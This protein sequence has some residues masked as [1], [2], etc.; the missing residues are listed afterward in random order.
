[1]VIRVET[2]ADQDGVYA[3]E[4]AAFQRRAEA[5]LVDLL[6]SQAGT[7]LS[8]VAEEDGMI[9]GHVLFSPVV[10]K[11]PDGSREGQ[12]MGPVA[13]DPTRQ[14]QGIGSALILDGLERL[15]R[16]GHAFVV[17]EGSPRTYS[18]FGFRDAL[19]LDLEC[20][21]NPPPGCFMVLELQPN[22]LDGV[23]GKVFYRPEFQ[24]IG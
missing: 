4:A 21:F 13:V 6:R 11:T 18:R 12:G 8:L 7:T 23:R 20:E 10:V 24:A 14:R 9:L 2:P 17:V 5:D 16:A 1:M 15:R 22:G 3:V 19:L